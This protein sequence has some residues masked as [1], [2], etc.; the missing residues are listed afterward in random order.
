M[1]ILTFILGLPSVSKDT[2]MMD[3]VDQLYQKMSEMYVLSLDVALRENVALLLAKDDRFDA[4]YEKVVRL[5]KI[6]D[7][8]F[9][10]AKFDRSANAAQISKDASEEISALL[11]IVQ[12]LSE[13]LT[14][15]DLH[16]V[17][18]DGGQSSLVRASRCTI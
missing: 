12:R 14:L 5:V 1:L 18:R 17:I 10:D 11:V 15:A 6:G 2:R 3:R 16:V 4:L 7:S 9:G 13:A 8:D